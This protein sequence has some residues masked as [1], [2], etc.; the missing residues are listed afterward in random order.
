MAKFK[1]G[2]SGNPSG[3]PKLDPELKELARAL[4][5]AA[6]RT[7]MEIM[8]NKNAAAAARVSAALAVLDRGHGKPVQVNE[9]TSKLAIAEVPDDTLLRWL[10][11]KLEYFGIGSDASSTVG[12]VTD[13]PLLPKR[14]MIGRN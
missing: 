3:R 10:T 4:T 12:N 6:L 7:L 11:T 5:P 1:K 9:L 14:S 13:T 2:E 8:K